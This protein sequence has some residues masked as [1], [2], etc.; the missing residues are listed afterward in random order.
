MQQTDLSDPLRYAL[1]PLVRAF[2]SAK[3]A[4]QAD[5]AAGARE[6]WAADLE[7]RAQQAIAQQRYSDLTLLEES[8]LAARA[9]FDWAERTARWESFLAIY[10]RISSLWS[11]RGL[12]D[13]RER[14][15]VRVIAAARAAGQTEQVARFLASL[16]RLK[17][18]LGDGAAGSLQSPQPPRP[19]CS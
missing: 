16:A 1:H 8:D 10:Q 7:L 4:K 3:L 12:F 9:F 11:V 19:R 2:A 5:F 17:S 15:T 18:Y 14:Y 13:V 6:R